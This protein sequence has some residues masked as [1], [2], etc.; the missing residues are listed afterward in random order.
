MT[1][2]IKLECNKNK[3]TTRMISCLKKDMK[4]L[5]SGILKDKTK[6]LSYIISP[7]GSLIRITIMLFIMV[8]CF[9]L[10]IRFS[11]ENIIVGKTFSTRK[12]YNY[13]ICKL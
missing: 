9:I 13:T 7:F 8:M 2:C 1:F 12:S 11:S 4:L 6:I 5:L 3:K 10:F